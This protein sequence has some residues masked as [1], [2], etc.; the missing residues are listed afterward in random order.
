[1]KAIEVTNLSFAYSQDRPLF[2]NLTFDLE[3]GEHLAVIGQNGSGKTTL[4][5]LFAGLLQPNQ[6]QIH[7][8]AEDY[9][10]RPIAE[11]AQKIAYVFQ[12]PD[13]QMFNRTVKAE[14]LFGPKMLGFSAA[15]R[16]KL[17]AEI[18][19]LCQLEEVLWRHPFDLSPSKRKGIALASALMMD[20]PIVIMDEPTAGLDGD[21]L[22]QLSEVLSHLKET[23]K[24]VLMI[25]HDLSFVRQHFRSALIGCQSGLF[26]REDLSSALADSNVV[27]A[28]KLTQ[29]LRKTE[30]RRLI[31]EGQL[32]LSEF[33]IAVMRKEE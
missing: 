15:K 20:T 31:N 33:V 28:A 24:T 22:R 1:M 10:G 19:D 21:N 26:S 6:G 11:Y 17:L 7:L 8:F 32:S 29:T 5:K 12:N 14:L 13:E 2:D 23:Q 9:V 4:M 27:K 3:A 18:V 30:A 25:S 16:E